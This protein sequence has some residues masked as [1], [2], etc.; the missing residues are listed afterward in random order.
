MIRQLLVPWRTSPPVGGGLCRSY[1]RNISTIIQI[2]EGGG[3]EKVCKNKPSNLTMIG[4]SSERT[5]FGRTTRGVLSESGESETTGSQVVD[6]VG[7][8]TRHDKKKFFFSGPGLVTNRL[9]KSGKPLLKNVLRDGLSSGDFGRA[10]IECEDRLRSG[11]KVDGKLVTT[12]I[13]TFGNAGELDKAIDREFVPHYD[14][15]FIC[16]LFFR[17]LQQDWKGH[18]D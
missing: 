11:E 4:L 3:E 1:A 2:N 16:P 5:K 15:L 7:Y 8:L 13:R 18:Q 9:T 14:A 17:S 6:G 12:I 10:V